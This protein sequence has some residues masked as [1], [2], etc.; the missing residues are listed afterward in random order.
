MP[1]NLCPTEMTQNELR[2]KMNHE[3]RET[4]TECVIWHCNNDYGEIVKSCSSW[5]LAVNQKIQRELQDK[6]R[7]IHG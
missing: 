6:L 1:Q 5:S 4:D 2:A 3:A 7:D